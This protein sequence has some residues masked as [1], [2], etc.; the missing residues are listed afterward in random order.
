MRIKS[1]FATAGMGLRAA[2][3]SSSRTESRLRVSAS[4]PPSAA[5]WTAAASE[6]LAVVSLSSPSL[7]TSEADFPS[8]S[9]SES[10]LEAGVPTEADSLSSSSSSTILALEHLR[11]PISSSSGE[12]CPASTFRGASLTS[13][14]E[15]VRSAQNFT[16]AA[17]SAKI[18]HGASRSSLSPR[19]DAWIAGKS[20]TVSTLEMRSTSPPKLSTLDAMFVAKASTPLVSSEWS[21]GEITSSSRSESN[22]ITFSRASSSSPPP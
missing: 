3:N 8:V 6:V 9:V 10:P 2:W 19:L 16:A 7:S 22:S 15:T 11:R 17:R 1:R 21:A 4:V 12:T 13:S 5:A 14:N 20:S 18:S